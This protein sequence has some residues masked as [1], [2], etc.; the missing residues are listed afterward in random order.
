MES[1]STKPKPHWHILGAGAIGCLFASF[2]IRSGHSVTLLVRD[3]NKAGLFD[4]QACIR[5]DSTTDQSEE[6][7]CQAKPSEE[8]NY[9]IDSLM[10]CTKAHQTLAALES[11][12]H[13]LTPDSTIILMQN[14]MGVYEQ[15]QQ[16][17]PGLNIFHGSTTEGAWQQSPF[18]IVHAGVGTTQIGSLSGKPANNIL[19]KFITS[20][21]ILGV[22]IG[23]SQ[24]IE[25]IL[26]RKLAVN[27]AVNPLTVL[28]QCRNG[29]LLDNQQTR[30]TIS[31][32][33]HEI[34]AV[35]N[36]W[37]HADWLEQLEE[38]VLT[39]IRKTAQNRSSMLQD[40]L[41]NTPTEINFI[42]GY[43]LDL[44]EKQNICCP[45][46]QKLYNHVKQLQG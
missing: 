15:I 18:H 42:T 6:W 21:Q 26:W 28:Y 4:K 44:A 7:T 1:N 37:D 34:T 31:L 10:V 16:H 8:V 12:K 35:A 30:Q 43:L 27:C 41:R 39:V 9:T 11:I 24:E 25:K 29:E 45:E 33:C 3:G 20:L 23:F 17:I 14:G 5:V 38:D 36:A 13:C 40:H 2:L 46:N 32:L 22:D 19:S